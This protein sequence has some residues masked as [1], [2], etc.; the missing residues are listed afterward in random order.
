M[1]LFEILSSVRRLQ[2]GGLILGDRKQMLVCPHIWGAAGPRPGPEQPLCGRL[3]VPPGNGEQ[4]AEQ[5]AGE[6]GSVAWVGQ[7]VAAYGPR[8]QCPLTS[9]LGPLRTA[10]S[11]EG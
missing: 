11:A 2:G 3:K 4:P 6:E 8:A 7:I 1:L 10:A 9:V 5:H